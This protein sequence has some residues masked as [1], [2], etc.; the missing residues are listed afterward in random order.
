MASAS[1]EIIWTQK[2]LKELKVNIRLP[3]S[4][5]W[6]NKFAIQLANNPI[7]HERSKHFEIDVHF[8]REKNA[9]GSLELKKLDPLIKLLTFSPSTPGSYFQIFIWKTWHV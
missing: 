2:F 9:T 4:L 8:I 5:L 7:F 6:D 1:C 3:V